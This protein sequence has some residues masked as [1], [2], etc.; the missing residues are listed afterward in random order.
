MQLIETVAVIGQGY[1]GLPLA[2]HCASTFRKVIGLD[3]DEFRIGQLRKGNS[4]IRD[5]EDEK[6]LSI[7]ETGVYEPSSDMSLLKT[8]QVI[9]ICVP[10]PLNKDGNPDLSY[11]SSAIDSIAKYALD[12]ALIIN[13]STSY[14]GTLR[15]VIKSELVKTRPNSKFLFAVA[16]ERIDPGNVDW[17]LNLTPRI[18]GGLD[19]ES[20][21]AASA[22]YSRFCDRVIEVS[23]AEVAE[24][25]KLLE[26]SFR[27]VNIALVTELSEFC[28]RIQISVHEVIKAASSKPYGFMPFYPGIGVGGHCIPIDPLYLVWSGNQY[29][30]SFSLIERADS[31]NRNR[32][33]EISRKIIQIP[34]IKQS[35]VLIAGLSYKPGIADL[36][37]SPSIEIL[38]QLHSQLSNV[39]WWDPVVE[40]IGQ[41][42]RASLEEHFDLVLLMYEFNEQQLVKLSESCEKL[43]DCSGRNL[44]F[45]GVKPI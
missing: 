5:V 25:A 20:T 36:R 39:F 14:P 26:N 42:E 43:I 29:G 12:G 28:E 10:T 21:K 32:P 27:Q 1:V 40:S 35:R 34:N 19:E 38:R 30:V 2:V 31:I 15:G 44:W 22:F 13:E 16:P 33:V 8:A 4:P 41:E 11:V 3:L 45:E 24:T 23:S 17:E 18:I 7:L 6:L 37:E 9:V